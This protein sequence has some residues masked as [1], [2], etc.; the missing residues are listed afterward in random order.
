MKLSG[1]ISFISLAVYQVT[2]YNLFYRGRGVY[3][4]LL[5]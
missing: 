2:W 3:I 5:L 4:M 1:A